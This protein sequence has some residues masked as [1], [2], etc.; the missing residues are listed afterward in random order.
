MSTHKN[1]Q[2][3]NYFEPMSSFYSPTLS[4]QHPTPQVAR[5]FNFANLTFTNMEASRLESYL[6]LFKDMLSILLELFSEKPSA[7]SLVKRLQ[8]N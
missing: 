4:L 7:R 6:P 2:S 8:E 5:Q 1:K 3:T